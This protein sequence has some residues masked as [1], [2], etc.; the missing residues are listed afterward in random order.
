MDTAPAVRSSSPSR[1]PPPR[2]ELHTLLERAVQAG[3]TGTDVSVLCALWTHADRHGGAW[4]SQPRLARLARRCERTVR[5]SVQRLDALGVIVRSVPS[6]GTR[7][8]GWTDPATGERRWSRRSTVY[9]IAADD[10]REPRPEAAPGLDAEP[11]PEIAAAAARVAAAVT[12][13][14]SRDDDAPMLAWGEI[15]LALDELDPAPTVNDQG[16]A[17][18]VGLDELDPAPTVNDQGDALDELD[19]AP[20]VEHQEEQS[21]NPLDVTADAPAEPRFAR[22]AAAILA[23]VIDR[24]PLPPKCP[25]ETLSETSL[26][27]READ[28]PERPPNPYTSPP[29]RNGPFRAPSPPPQGLTRPGTVTASARPPTRSP[30]APLESKAAAILRAAARRRR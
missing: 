9:V 3:A 23:K 11:S 20:V 25:R 18:G 28:P 7:R 26:R 14:R 19:P 15:D 5:S 16:D 6:H 30:P 21:P 4:P 12:R 10:S 1:R 8:W 13:A 22:V 17:H 2:A 24:Q 29:P 27:A